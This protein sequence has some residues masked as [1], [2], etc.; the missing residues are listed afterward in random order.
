MIHTLWQSLIFW[1]W[2]YLVASGLTKTSGL[3]ADP[4]NINVKASRFNWKQGGTAVWK[5]M[6]AIKWARFWCEQ[7]WVLGT[8]NRWLSRT[9]LHASVPLIKCGSF[10]FF[11]VACIH[12][13]H[14]IMNKLDIWL[15]SASFLLF[16]SVFWPNKFWINQ[17]IY[18][19]LTFSWKINEND[20]NL[21]YN[22]IQKI[23]NNSFF[24]F[25]NVWC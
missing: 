16:K 18:S 4:T 5:T 8:L 13:I 25:F 19:V 21:N 1:G 23:K 9:Q 2:K 11:R 17:T 3:N 10:Y 6:H 24:F 12:K 22:K 20:S 14:S 7:Q 15:C